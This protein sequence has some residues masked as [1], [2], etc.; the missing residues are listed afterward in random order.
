[1]TT[2]VNGVA[3]QPTTMGGLCEAVAEALDR[4][5]WLPVPGFALKLL[6]GEGATVGLHSLPGGVRLLYMDHI[7]AVVN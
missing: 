4:P 7:L 1:V 3:P 6:L 2:L 5:N